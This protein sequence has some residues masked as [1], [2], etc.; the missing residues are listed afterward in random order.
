MLLTGADPGGGGGSGWGG[1]GGGL[2]HLFWRTPKL[3]NVWKKR[4]CVFA[5]ICR[6]LV[7]NNYPYHFQFHLNGQIQWWMDPGGQ[8]PSPGPGP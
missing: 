8:R 4:Y 7:V 1:G 2:T 3:Y 6:V 5:R